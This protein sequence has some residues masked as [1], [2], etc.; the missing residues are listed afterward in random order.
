MFQKDYDKLQQIAN[1]ISDINSAIF[2]LEWDQQTNMPQEGAAERAEQIGTLST[3][4]HQ[5]ATSN[6]LGN[7]LDKLSNFQKDLDP[8]S[9]E[10]CLIKV[11]QRDYEQKTKIPADL[12]GRFSQATA[13][14][15][16]KWERARHENEFNIF[17]ESLSEIFELRKQMAKCHSPFDCIYDPLLDEFEPE[18]ATKTVQ[19][20]F[21]IIKP[22]QIAL[23][24]KI[25]EDYKRNPIDDSFLFQNFD[26]K[27]QWDFGV[28]VLTDMGYDWK[29]GRQD[30]AAH[31]FTTTF[32]LGD[33]RI[34]T[35]IH[36]NNFMSGLFSSIHEGGH[37]LYEQGVARNLQR[38]SLGTGASLAIHESQ[39]RLWENMVGRSLSFWH[40]YYPI[41]QAIFPS[42][43]G[44]V[45]INNFYRAINKVEP[46]L[47]RVEAD[48]VTYNLHIMLRLELEIALLNGEIQVSDLPDVWNCKMQEYLG[49]T[50]DSDANGVLQDVHWSCGIIG[51]FPTYALGNMISAMF[52][53]KAKSSLDNLDAKISQGNLL[54]LRNYLKETLHC[55]GAKFTP[56]ELMKKIFNSKID[57]SFYINYLSNKYEE[58]N[59]MI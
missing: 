16:H 48:E 3:I 14:G 39:S 27:K 37:A 15:Q 45:S 1:K 58:I 9:Y 8:E 12:I 41:L 38:T 10:F 40:H 24:Q 57:E 25:Q 50:P 21:N 29:S 31:P 19:D 51:Y 53:D 43:L 59:S 34:T 54:P 46:S 35:R 13:I 32:G 11:M 47:I 17:E 56:N 2:L 52:F 42:Q 23:I 20:I 30:K 49:V 36:S 22:Q 44:N 28:K 55:H 4:S 6:Q 33:V 18:M 7:L 26:E 5:E